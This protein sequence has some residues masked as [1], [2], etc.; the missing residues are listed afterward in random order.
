MKRRMTIAAALLALAILLGGCGARETVQPAAGT[1]ESVTENETAA[2]ALP[3]DR[4]DE[5]TSGDAAAQS[6]PAQA[7]TSAAPAPA[8]DTTAAQTTKPGAST[9]KP[10]ATTKPGASTTKPAATTK[11][12]A[13]TTKPAATTKPGATTTKPAATTKPGA[14]VS[15]PPVSTTKSGAVTTTNAPQLKGGAVQAKI[16]YLNDAPADYISKLTAD[17]LEHFGITGEKQQDVLKHPEK[18]RAYTIRLDFRNDEDVPVTFYYLD[19][20]DNGKDDVFI[21]G[22]F[23]A[24]LGLNPDAQI[25]ERFYLLA[26]RSD[27]DGQVLQKV[28]SMSMRLQY[29]ATPEDDEATP[30]FV[31]AKVG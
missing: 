3:T 20:T 17:K 2:N 7:D 11:P 31:Y 13:S 19:V 23:S 21:N 14:P 26:R 29:A 8:G 6:S 9:T 15:D 28:N 30:A 25:T 27:T 18:W 10:A 1:T 24:E 22:D 4:T 12:G 16:T 5:A